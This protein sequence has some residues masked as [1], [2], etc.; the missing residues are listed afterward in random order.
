MGC[1]SQIQ[2]LEDQIQKINR[3]NTLK[4]REIEKIKKEKYLKEIEIE[5]LNNKVEEIAND[6]EEEKKNYENLKYV[7]NGKNIQINEKD[8]KIRNLE[9][10]KG[11]LIWQKNQNDRKINILNNKNESLEKKVKN[12]ENKIYFQEN[13][14]KDAR[15]KLKEKDLSNQRMASDIR[16]FEQKEKNYK[17]Q[18]RDA[19]IEN[20]NQNQMIQSLQYETNNL[21]FQN[22]N[23]KKEIQSLQ[24]DKQ[25]LEE[26][27]DIMGNQVNNYQIYAENIKRQLDE[28]IKCNQNLENQMNIYQ[29][30]QK[31]FENAI[32][33][34][35]NENEKKNKEIKQLENKFSQI[36]KEKES[37]ELLINNLQM[38][39]FSL[40]NQVKNLEGNLLE[41]KNANSNM[42]KEL[43]DINKL[44]DLEKNQKESLE[45]QLN[46]YKEQIEIN[47]FYKL[48]ESE[49]MQN[50]ALNF[51]RDIKKDIAG[52]IAQ[53]FKK[54]FENTITN[55]MKSEISNISQKENFK[56]YFK[57]TAEEYYRKAI[58]EFSNKTKH[59]NILLIGKSGVGKSTL[60][61]A[62]LKEDRAQTQL[63]KPCTE[64]INKYESQNLRLWDSQGIELKENN[65]LK[66]VLE[67]TRN[68]IINNNNLGDP[69]KY[70]HCIWY[71]TT[72][73]RFEE[74]EEE[75]MKQLI[76]MYSDNSLPLI[77]VYTLALSDE[78]F[79]GMK[80]SIKERIP[81][82]IDIMPVL[83]KDY[84]LKGGAT[85]KAYGKEDLI[86]LSLSKFKNAIDHVSFST[87]KHLVIHM[88]D[89]MINNYQYV[90]QEV[91]RQLNSLKSF[92]ESK[93]YLK[94]ILK[95]FHTIITGQE[96]NELS[97]VIIKSSIDSW[98]T[99][100]KLEIESYSN[101]LL[102]DSKEN[103]RKLYLDELEKYK[104]KKYIKT[105]EKE[106]NNKQIVY[107]TNII[108]EIEGEIN[109]E[110][111]NF[112]FKNIVPYIF[113]EYFI[114]IS[115]VI[116]DNVKIIIENAKKE[117]IGVMQ[118][119]IANNKNFNEIFGFRKKILQNNFMK[120]PEDYFNWI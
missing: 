110:K 83:A 54:Y 102:K 37:K 6:L 75:S 84:T 105:D 34:F 103:F 96:I 20:N 119:E 76:N 28:K 35:E 21:K 50:K 89:D 17:K 92:D 68:L 73:Q 4:E 32:K 33:K 91:I 69:D 43:E 71:C 19:K 42:K 23:N 86:N 87:V 108:N 81:K 11:E 85:V 15:E 3:E 77:L 41:N 113:K 65:N 115:V 38:K 109:K 100:C 58:K 9:N 29:M 114:L 44:L 45:L 118:E 24:Y 12:L 59:L 26:K 30:Q 98:C 2:I 8:K 106:D 99:N 80:D 48:F 66:K 94:N 104:N 78:I 13:E 16:D 117:I 95:E 74:V 1:S 7:V 63:G 40:E 22:I 93:S 46:G 82:N 55:E 70:I 90:Y 25:A 36:K 79:N 111:N 47:N 60:I 27:V 67:I 62:I 56:D 88:F 51:L 10:Q 57:K 53:K 97:N 61:N 107:C 5:E 116:K 72:G 64:G 101:N 112:I 31:E 49:I 52:T 39:K 120:E 18:L 14:L